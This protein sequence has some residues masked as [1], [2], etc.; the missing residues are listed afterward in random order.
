[1][2]GQ[3]HIQGQQQDLQSAEDSSKEQSGVKSCLEFLCR[4]QEKQIEKFRI[5]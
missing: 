4:N 3:I 1:M 5:D 2:I